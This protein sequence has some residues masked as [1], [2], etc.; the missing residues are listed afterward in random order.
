MTDFKVDPESYM[1]ILTAEK[2]SNYTIVDYFRSPGDNYL[3]EEIRFD[4]MTKRKDAR[5]RRSPL[6]QDMGNADKKQLY[7]YE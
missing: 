6:S 5:L 2:N 1:P 3:T 4:N 7:I